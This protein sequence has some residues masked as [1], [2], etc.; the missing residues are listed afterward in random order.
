MPVDEDQLNN[1]IGQFITDLGATVQA[2]NVVIGDRLG[3]YR[4]LSNE[5]RP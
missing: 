5:I 2:G 1:L 4:A 3:F